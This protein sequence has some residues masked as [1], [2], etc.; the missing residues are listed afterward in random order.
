VFYNGS[1]NIQNY[2]TNKKQIVD[3]NALIYLLY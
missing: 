2:Q 1:T 3:L